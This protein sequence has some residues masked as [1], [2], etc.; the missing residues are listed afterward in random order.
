MTLRQ[1]RWAVLEVKL[2]CAISTEDGAQ[3]LGR[4]LEILN[5]FKRQ[6]N[7]ATPKGEESEN[8]KQP[9]VQAS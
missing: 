5:D 2:L 7:L 3:R 6:N 4:V 8:I 1:I 9:K